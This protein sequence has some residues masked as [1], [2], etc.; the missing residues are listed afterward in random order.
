[1]TTGWDTLIQS[2]PSE[3]SQASTGGS[4]QRVDA[5]FVV[6]GLVQRGVP[7]HIAEGFALN[8]KDE[9]GFDPGV[10][11]R[12][13]TVAG[14]RGGFGLYQLTG[15]RRRAYEAFAAQKG[16]ALDDP[17]AQLDFAV[18]ELQGPEQRAAS[19]IYAT[20]TAGEAAAAITTYFLRPA[21]VNRDR[22]VEKYLSGATP[23]FGASS[24]QDSALPN[25]SRLWLDLGK[26]PG[27]AQA[28]F[29]QQLAAQP[30]RLWLN[31]GAS[32]G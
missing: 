6:N 26:Q 12:T 30:N 5:A 19:K 23:D 15:P 13:P 11:E 22:R 16:V 27:Q 1:M 10:N 18:L 17:N 28:Q 7:Q 21:A 9:S 8:I 20:S 32:N 2:Y 29:P 31:L 25:S 3:A 14:S 4:G 24:G